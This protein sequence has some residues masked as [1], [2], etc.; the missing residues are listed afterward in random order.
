LGGDGRADGLVE[1]WRRLAENVHEILNGANPGDIPIYQPTKFELVINLKAAK[2]L[3]LTLPPA[4]LAAA[5]DV[6]E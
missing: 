4:L 1:L 5:D 6:I 3:G 2:E